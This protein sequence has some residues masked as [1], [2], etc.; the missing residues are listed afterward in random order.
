MSDDPSTR[1]RRITKPCFRICSTH[2]S[3]SQAHFYLYAQR[4]IAN[5]AECTFGLLRYLLGGDLPS[6]TAHLALF[7]TR[8]HGMAL[9]TYHDESGISPVAPPDPKAR[10]QRLPP[11]LRTT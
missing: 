1:N 4:T 5:R 6:Q 8:I 7:M 10:I 2:Q 11:I 3:R 9:E